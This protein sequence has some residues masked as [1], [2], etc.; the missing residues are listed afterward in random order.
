MFTNKTKINKISNLSECSSEF[1]SHKVSADWLKAIKNSDVK[2]TNT[3]YTEFSV[4]F[5]KLSMASI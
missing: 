2:T 1:N 3:P 5:L 4:Y